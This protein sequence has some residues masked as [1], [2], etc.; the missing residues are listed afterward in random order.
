MFQQEGK[1]K[2]M[3]TNGFAVSVYHPETARHLLTLS[4]TR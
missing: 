2:R 1:R 3:N 4:R